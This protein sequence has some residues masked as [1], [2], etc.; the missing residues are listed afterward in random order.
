MNTSQLLITILGALVNGA[1]VLGLAYYVVRAN[2]YPRLGRW[3][4]VLFLWPVFLLLLQLGIKWVGAD[5]AP[6]RFLMDNAMRF[7]MLGMCLIMVGLMLTFVDKGIAFMQH[8]HQQ[9]NAKN[10]DR[11]PVRWLFQYPERIRR[12]YQYGFALGSIPV[13]YGIFF[14][15]KF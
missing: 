15:M 12:I 2:H 10:L 3:G 14:A 7:M 9:H 5:F 1:V 11:I 4:R 13:L 6:T 8:F